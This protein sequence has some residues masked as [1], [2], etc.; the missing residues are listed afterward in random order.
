MANGI[1]TVSK[2]SMQA[3]LTS[4]R[5]FLD[6]TGAKRKEAAIQTERQGLSR[7]HLMQRGKSNTA[8]TVE[9]STSA[10][11]A[12][13]KSKVAKPQGAAHPQNPKKV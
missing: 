10:Q 7:N 13:N 4:Y 1:D 6:T 5:N 2:G 12:S 8:V 3:M 9:A 11:N